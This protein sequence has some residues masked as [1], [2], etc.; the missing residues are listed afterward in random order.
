MSLKQRRIVGDVIDMR[1]RIKCFRT[2]PGGEELESV[3]EPRMIQLALVGQC[4][5]WAKT[6][7]GTVDRSLCSR[8]IADMCV[9]V[10]VQTNAVCARGTWGADAQYSGTFHVPVHGTMP[11][12]IT[13]KDTHTLSVLVVHKKH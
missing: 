13:A 6:L 7:H 12:E 5:G 9:C 4:L 10:C 11:M 8:T 1:G 2:G 3:S